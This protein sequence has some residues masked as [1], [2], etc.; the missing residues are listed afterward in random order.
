MTSKSLAEL[1]REY[2]SGSSINPKTVKKGKI[3]AGMVV[4]AKSPSE[5][6]KG[7]NS[8]IEDENSDMV[9]DN[10]TENFEALVMTVGESEG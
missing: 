4:K 8:I 2:R 5:V 9:K 10:A 6:W 7:H 3:I 1:A